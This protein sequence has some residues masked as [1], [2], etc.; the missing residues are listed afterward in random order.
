MSLVGDLVVNLGVDHRGFGRDLRSSRGQLRTFS[1]SVTKILTGIGAGFVASFAF[2]KVQEGLRKALELGR[3][4]VEL[5]QNQIKAEQKLAS[6]LTAT[7]GAAGLSAR[8]IANYASHLQNLTNFGDEATIAAAGMLATFK[9]I[10]GSL[11]KDALAVA[12]DLS[13]VMEQDL[14]S[15]IV[16]V[17]KALNDPIR[18]LTSLQRIGVA[19]TDEQK[20]QIANLQEQGDLLGA[21]KIIM[22]ELTSEF[23]GAAQAMAEPTTQLANTFGDIKELIGFAILP[24]VNEVAESLTGGATQLSAMRAEAELFGEILARMLRQAK[25]FGG[26]LGNITAN[27][28]FGLMLSGGKKLLEATGALTGGQAEERMSFHETA[29]ARQQLKDMQQKA[30]MAQ[31]AQ[32]RGGNKNERDTKRQIDIAEKTQMAAERTANALTR[33]AA[34]VTIGN[35]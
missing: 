13:V 16:Q 32:G 4:G 33:G 10:R 21:Q 8:E 9:Q 2:H 35:L 3:E 23:G 11:F 5:A 6:V 28:S 19:F 17:G 30:A 12:Q 20:E 24:A 14:K 1:A 31:R 18:G 15:S 26:V 22:E 7:G 25:E 34:V 27:S 29:L